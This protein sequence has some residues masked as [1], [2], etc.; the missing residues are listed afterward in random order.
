M[1][2]IP[3]TVE[4]LSDW[5]ENTPLLAIGRFPLAVPGYKSDSLQ[6]P[7]ERF[8]CRSALRCVRGVVNE[9]HKEST[10]K[11]DRSARQMRLEEGF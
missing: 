10:G 11:Q 9:W 3:N 6:S 1:V 8:T 2:A 5:R 7:R 4:P